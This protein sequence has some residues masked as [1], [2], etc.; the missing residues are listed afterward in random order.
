MSKVIAFPKGMKGHPPQTLD[1]MAE[2]MLHRKTNYINDIVDF[3]GTEL[4]TR[5]SMDGF[6]MDEDAFAKDF[7]FTLEGMRSC[8]YRTAGI[9]HPLQKS[10]DETIKFDYADDD[11]DDDE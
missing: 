11:D 3:Y 5:I 1:E 10:V 4:L 7:A 8:L 6:E 2:N 9:H